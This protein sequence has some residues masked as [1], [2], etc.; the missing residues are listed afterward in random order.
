M[1][2]CTEGKG[3]DLKDYAQYQ[4]WFNVFQFSLTVLVAVGA[5]W[6]TREKADAATI[7]AAKV[8]MQKRQEAAKLARDEQCKAHKAETTGATGSLQKLYNHL[9]DEISHLPARQEIRDLSE[10][11]K[12]LTERIGNLDGRMS[13]VNRAVDLINQFLIE[14]GGKK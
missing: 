7:T 3:G 2:S 6:R 5:W 8:E 12:H 14:Q 10:S 13:G 4:F 1:K 11:M 9:H